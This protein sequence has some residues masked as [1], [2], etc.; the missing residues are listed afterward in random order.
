MKFAFVCACEEVI[1]P[2]PPKDFFYVFAVVCSIVRIDEDIVEVDNNGDVKHIGKD[3]VDKVLE[4][5]GCIGRSK[6]HNMSF[7][8]TIAGAECIF[9]FISFGNMD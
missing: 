3:V 6:W 8:G 4:S 9:P 2:G 7:K 1:L 5:H